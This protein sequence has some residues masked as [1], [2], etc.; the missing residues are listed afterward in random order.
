M[1]A[2]TSGNAPEEN[3]PV[4]P[5]SSAIQPTPCASGSSAKH[6]TMLAHESSTMPRCAPLWSASQPQAA[7]ANMRAAAGSDSTNAI[8]PALRPR[9]ERYGGKYAR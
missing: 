8:S 2:S 9:A 7:G 5:M 4:A 3:T 1:I 6:A